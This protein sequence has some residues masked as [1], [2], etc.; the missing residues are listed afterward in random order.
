MECVFWRGPRGHRPL[1]PSANDASMGS[2]GR[3]RS[4]TR[5]KGLAS[6]GFG[7]LEP[8]R[9]S[10]DLPHRRIN[11]LLPHRVS[12]MASV[13]NTSLCNLCQPQLTDH[14]ICAAC[15]DAKLLTLLPKSLQGRAY[16]C[17]GSLNVERGIEKMGSLSCSNRIMKHQP[18][19]LTVAR[20]C[21]LVRESSSSSASCLS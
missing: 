19:A 14:A 21:N 3:C 6:W 10:E 4:R 18:C 2:G 20:V 13:M 9:R 1:S 17:Q 11:D 12:S 8:L 15:S 16:F 7:R 5:K